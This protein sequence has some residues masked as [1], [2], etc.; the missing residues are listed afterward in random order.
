MGTQIEL[1]VL[2]PEDYPSLGDILNDQETMTDLVL[3]FKRKNWSESEIKKR[4]DHFLQLHSENRGVTFVVVLKSDNTICGTCGFKEIDWDKRE[5][6]FGII[7]SKSVWGQ[8]V[9]KECHH[10]SLDYAFDKLDLD[11]VYFNTDLQNKR[12]QKNFTKMGIEKVEQTDDGFLRYE[13]HRSRWIE[14][15]EYL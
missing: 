3:Y 9:S 14:L 10:L 11:L 1:R 4:H 6:E 12:M 2:T 7:L 5:S 13:I 15:K 8:G